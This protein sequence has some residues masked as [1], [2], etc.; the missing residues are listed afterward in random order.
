MP[1]DF[2]VRTLESW[3][4]QSSGDAPPHIGNR[5]RAPPAPPARMPR[6]AHTLSSASMPELHAHSSSVDPPS[7]SAAS[8]TVTPPLRRQAPAIP[9][10]ETP[11]TGLRAYVQRYWRGKHDDTRHPRRRHV[12]SHDDFDTPAPR[13]R[14]PPP[15]PPRLVPCREKKCAGR[16]GLAWSAPTATWPKELPTSH[17]TSGY[18]VPS[19]DHVCPCCRYDER[20]AW[21]RA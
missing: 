20:S 2:D 8:G 7:P 13:R 16:R 1:L 6:L 3:S 4:R 17:G 14:A 21:C 15:P 5:R 10:R 11:P 18:H 12:T 19:P 9:A